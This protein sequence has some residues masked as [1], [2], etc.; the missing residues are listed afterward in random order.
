MIQPRQKLHV[1][2]QLAELTVLLSSLSNGGQSFRKIST[3]LTDVY[4]MVSYDSFAPDA[5]AWAV[6]TAVNASNGEYVQVGEQV[7]MQG[8]A[9]MIGVGKTLPEMSREEE[10]A[11]LAS[12]KPHACFLPVVN[13]FIVDLVP[14]L[15]MF[16]KIV[17]RPIA[18]AP[19]PDEAIHV[20]IEA[21][22]IKNR[23]ILGIGCLASIV[24]QALISAGYRDAEYRSGWFPSRN[25][26]DSLEN[27]E[28]V[29]ADLDASDARHQTPY[30]SRKIVLDELPN[31]D[32]ES[33][34]PRTT[35]RY[36]DGKLDDS[37]GGP[38]WDRQAGEC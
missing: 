8:F 23:S 13:G 35:A 16:S 36:I 1:N 2:K 17:R 18:H 10:E 7:F 19:V 29:L 22:S 4:G 31:L 25:F 14:G 15:P 32:E 5:P 28:D 20:K 12:E 27:P 34:T 3:F 38:Y 11:W 6:L 30:R 24:R 37:V 9:L 26:V 33:G 21:T